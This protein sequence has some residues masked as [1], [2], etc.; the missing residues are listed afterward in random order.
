M[1]TWAAV[2]PELG[3]PVLGD[4]YSYD[5]AGSAAADLSDHAGDCRAAFAEVVSDGF[6]ELRGV[7]A[8]Q[9]V[10][11]VGSVD[12]SFHDLPPVF[13]ELTHILTHHAEQLR[14]LRGE[15][16]AALGRAQVR[17]A[18]LTSSTAELARAQAACELVE[19][20][21]AQL[22]IVPE[23]DA[24]RLIALQHAARTA[25]RRV[26]AADVAHDTAEHD[27]TSSR[28]EFDALVAGEAELVAATCRR[29]GDVH[30]G[31]LKDPGRLQSLA[32][33]IGAWTLGALGD[34]AGALAAGVHA[35]AEGRFI[36]ALHHL[37]D[38]LDA[39]VRVCTVVA[40]ALVVVGMTVCPAALVALPAVLAIGRGLAAADASINTVLLATQHPH[41]AT[42][43]P[44][45]VVEVVGS[46]IAAAIPSGAG[47]AV[48]GAARA[49]ARV[50]AAAGAGASNP[51][52]VRT[53]AGNRAVLDAV[54]SGARQVVNPATGRTVAGAALGAMARRAQTEV[55]ARTLQTGVASAVDGTIGAVAG[56]LVTPALGDTL[57][58]I[59]SGA[60]ARLNAAVYGPQAGALRPITRA[61]N[62]LRLWN[63]D[64]PT[65][66]RGHAQYHLAPC[67]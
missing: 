23:P 27:L 34:L 55:A 18:A 17:R 16:A 7:T 29:I 50:L 65:L 19:R 49:E 30:L 62:D 59:D 20:Q 10:E 12:G 42:G 41:P 58:W 44:V 60:E 39:A 63:R 54:A 53:A 36:D 21:L 56:D 48:A 40:L 33:A 47:T 28:W 2:F 52:F 64:G 31:D 25:R 61:L 37:S 43:R 5:V 45:G 67:P 13:A 6:A 14:Q 8:T 4:P 66:R 26:G 24:G 22:Q 1:S 35:V 38:A 32:G 11:V 57:E 3:E 9:L 46:A 51:T 15:A